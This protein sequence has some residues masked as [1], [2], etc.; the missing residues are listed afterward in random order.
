MRN[1]RFFLKH[2]KYSFFLKGNAFFCTFIRSFLLYEIPHSSVFAPLI[3]TLT[4]FIVFQNSFSNGFVLDDQ[5]QIVSSQIIH[6]VKHI[7]LVFLTTVRDVSSTNYFLGHY[8][9]PLMFSSYALLYSLGNGNP[10]FFHIYQV[11]IHIANSILVFSI[12][13]RFISKYVAL[14][15]S[16]TFLIHPATAET[17]TY[18][19]NLQD[20]LV[21]FFGLSSL[22]LIQTFDIKQWKN[23]I[24]FASVLFLT[25]LSKESSVLFL[26]IF[27]TFLYLFKKRLVKRSLFLCIFPLALYCVL[28][29]TAIYYFVQLHPYVSKNIS[30]ST[31][32]FTAPKLVLFYTKELI[33]PSDTISSVHGSLVEYFSFQGVV[34]PTF[35]LT[36][37]GVLIWTIYIKTITKNPRAKKP[38]FFFL[39]WFL[40]GIGFHLHLI[41]LDTVVAKRWLYIPLIGFL[42]LI[43]VCS[44][45]LIRNKGAMRYGIAIGATLVLLL[46]SVQTIRMNTFWKSNETVEQHLLQF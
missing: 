1:S 36:I 27:L 25:L 12:F 31:K 29:L 2:D 17:V 14:L 13:H 40:A 11:I 38:F 19:A 8:Y 22:L 3:L 34:L 20:I 30:F 35:I 37:F 43:G 7:P 10:L 15:L 46:L 21:V 42:G 32:L 6:T 41:P 9:R 39:I 33:L 24:L 26:I 23:G 4:G 28:R 16:L 45:I 18:I 44:D 5:V